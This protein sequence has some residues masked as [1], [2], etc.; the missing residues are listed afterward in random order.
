MPTRPIPQARHSHNDGYARLAAL[1]SA[2]QPA[3]TLSD[4]E[5]LRDTIFP[6]LESRL[7][8]D[9]TRLLDEIGISKLRRIVPLLR[10]LALPDHE[11]PQSVQEQLDRCIAESDGQ[12]GDGLARWLLERAAQTPFSELHR[13]L[14]GSE[15][16]VLHGIAHNGAV[17]LVLSVGEYETLERVLGNRATYQVDCRRSA[18]DE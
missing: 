6:Y 4:L 15:P 10:V 7:Q 12:Q 2:E 17:A 16:L 9:V 11:G 14:R 1:L 5:A 18:S 13:M 8:I 3:S